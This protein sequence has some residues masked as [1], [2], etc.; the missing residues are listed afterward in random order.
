MYKRYAMKK[1]SL[2]CSF[3]VCIILPMVCAGAESVQTE[4]IQW[5]SF[6][7]GAWEHSMRAKEKQIE[8][9]SYKLE[10]DTIKNNLY[11]QI[12]FDIPE[13]IGWKRVNVSPFWAHIP[14]LTNTRYLNALQGIYGLNITQ[15]LPSGGSL[16]V[17]GSLQ[18][19]YLLQAE[20]FRHTPQFSLLYR[21]PLTR[22]IAAFSAET[23]AVQTRFEIFQT[24][25]KQAYNQFMKILLEGI[26]ELDTMRAHT[27]YYR[28][29]VAYHTAKYDEI[30]KKRHTGNAAALEVLDAKRNMLKAQQEYELNRS[31]FM[32]KEKAF[33]VRYGD[34]ALVLHETDKRNLAD[35]LRCTNTRD[36]YEAQLL[37]EKKQLLDA[38]LLSAKKD[39][40]PQ[41][42]V[43]FSAAPDELVFRFSPDYRTS[44][45]LLNRNTP[46]LFNASIGIVWSPDYF[47]RAAAKS[48]LLKN[49]S[50]LIDLQLRELHEQRQHE[51]LLLCEKI[52]SLEQA[53]CLMQQYTDKQSL[54]LKEYRRLYE[55]HSIT[56][57]A[58]EQINAEYALQIYLQ[59]Q[60]FWQLIAAK[61]E[62]L[63]S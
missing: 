3:L 5:K 13:I 61:A 27:E 56:E 20:L 42:L 52:A 28:L 2:L 36:N 60:T 50:S 51:T 23:R 25:H 22:G 63:F 30:E 12:T 14:A 26:A 39:E 33:S 37:T 15:K 17:T 32:L 62:Y 31:D 47:S 45:E 16:T 43:K 57:S 40:A 6:F 34:S 58:Y 38:E 10:A 7:S 8:L 21:Q 59:T 46:W 1:R 48:E 54:L 11:P 49:R 9:Q 18:S 44:W 55:E 19:E 4:P 53:Y 24:M 41:L 35:F 29:N